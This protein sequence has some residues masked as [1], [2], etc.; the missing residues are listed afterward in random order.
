MTFG[1]AT[2]EE[3]GADKTM[4]EE[5]IL[6]VVVEVVVTTIVETILMAVVEGVVP[7]TMIEEGAMMEVAQTVSKLIEEEETMEAVV[8]AGTILEPVGEGELKLN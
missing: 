1:E 2:T 3:E 8:V 4:I 5:T 6:M 7:L